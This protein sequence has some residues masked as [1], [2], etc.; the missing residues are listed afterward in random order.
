MDVTESTAFQ[1]TTNISS[2]SAHDNKGTI[3]TNDSFVHW[4]YFV[5]KQAAHHFSS[6]PIVIISFDLYHWVKLFVNKMPGWYNIRNY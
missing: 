1:Q 3:L 2:R 6:I 5:M 4:I